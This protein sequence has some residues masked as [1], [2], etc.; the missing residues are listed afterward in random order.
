[1]ES[2]N[3]FVENYP[4][5]YQPLIVNLLYPPWVEAAPRNLGYYQYRSD[6]YQKQ[7]RYQYLS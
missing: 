7:F 1:M 3:I 6:N 5:E 2:E 4:S